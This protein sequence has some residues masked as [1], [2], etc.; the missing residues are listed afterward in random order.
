M[1]IT[2]DNP[3]LLHNLIAKASSAD[4]YFRATIGYMDGYGSNGAK[5]RPFRQDIAVRR[6]SSWLYTGTMLNATQCASVP[7][8]QYARKR[9][10]KDGPLF[11]TRA[12]SKRTKRY[13]A[14][15]STHQPS[16]SVIAKIAEWGD[17][18]EE[19]TEPTP[20]LRLLSTVNEWQEGFEFSILRFLYL[21]IC[22]NA[23]V[24]P[25]MNGPSDGGR[26][27]PGELFILSSQWTKVCP[28]RPGDDVLVRGYTY[29][30]NMGQE[31]LFAPEEIIH[32]RLPNVGNVDGVSATDHLYYGKGKAEAAWTAL[33]LH[34]SKRV[35]DQAK[36][37]NMGRPDWIIGIEGAS[38]EALQ[39]VEAKVEQK[40]RG[41][42][43]AGKML[44][45]NGKV[46]AQAL[47]IPDP[48]IGDSDKVI[49][50]LA[51]ILG[52]PLYKF[53]GN[54]PVKANSEIQDI[55]WLRDTILPYLRIDEEK[56][57]AK[58]VPLWGIDDDSFLAYD[59]PVPS[60][61]TAEIDRLTKC[62]VGYI[63]TPN[64]ARAELGD[65]P[66]EGGDTLLVPSTVLPITMLGQAT[67]NP[68]AGLF[69]G[70]TMAAPATTPAPTEATPAA[71][72]QA[73]TP[74]LT[75]DQ[76]SFALNVVGQVT[77]GTLPRD[78]GIALLGAA[79]I[80]PAKATAIMGN[81]GTPKPTNPNPVSTPD[82]ETAAGG[83]TAP[84]SLNGAQ[85]T[86]LAGVLEKLTAGSLAPGVA[87]EMIVSLGIGRE[88]AQGMVDETEA[89]KDDGN[90]AS[91]EA[92]NGS[93]EPASGTTTD[94]NGGA[95]TDPTAKAKGQVDDAVRDVRS[96]GNAGGGSGK[97]TG[98]QPDG[99]PDSASTHSG[100]GPD[101]AGVLPGQPG[102]TGSEMVPALRAKAVE[103]GRYVLSAKVVKSLPKYAPP[104]DT[105]EELVRLLK[106][107]FAKQ[108]AE[109][110]KHVKSV[111]Q[112]KD[113]PSGVPGIK[114]DWTAYDDELAAIVK[115]ELEKIAMSAVAKVKPVL[116][117]GGASE[118]AFKVVDANLPKAVEDL[119]LKFA[120]STNATTAMK[121]D[122][123]REAL[124]TEI[125]DGIFTGDTQV[126][127]KDRVQSIYA[128][129]SDSRAETI[130]RTE[131]SRARHE[132]EVMTAK[133]SGVVKLKK[134]LV[135]ADACP[136][137]DA[138]AA[139]TG[140][141]VPVDQPYTSTDYGAVEGPPLHPRCQ[142]SQVLVLTDDQQV[143]E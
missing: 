134:W 26:S 43:N 104:Q 61:E 79:G 70:M 129:A 123:A 126:E 112:K 76:L 121:V 60:N 13:L 20:L 46:T 114:I 127:M 141:G 4:P 125:A 117:T 115:P 93:T 103:V 37:D 98:D 124:K 74:M 53:L 92:S 5:A 122:A 73:A 137:C 72:A 9:R 6:F 40:L 132:A 69:G 109:V 120:K 140:D 106:T 118:A 119:A 42:R 16:R 21:Q 44:A 136:E 28:G 75:A 86:A 85:I 25:V 81:A 3:L 45:A 1:T 48:E 54:D 142:C 27:T 131:A 105:P 90:T 57:N 18:F 107:F 34:D 67:A 66:T 110:L 87:V 77:A 52:V 39:L 97:S 31:E 19:I 50:E 8:R 59:D 80:E 65:E 88:T 89:N 22:G 41:V 62:V 108:G 10:S 128:E 99:I 82:G 17:D 7:L 91:T 101:A 130:A 11:R 100:I 83:S 68:L 24:H 133:S 64:E 71:T 138:L 55:G 94:A 116:I 47:N 32:W 56:L 36:Y 33:G 84:V 14:G 113:E 95:A 143:S 2:D 58:Y 63:K 15:G 51:A 49:A 23:Y 111:R 139:E 135:S 12:V 35:M 96:Q 78:S 30:R 102:S 29:G 38:A